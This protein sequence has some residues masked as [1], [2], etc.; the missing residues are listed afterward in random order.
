MNRTHSGTV[1]SKKMAFI[2]S[3]SPHKDN[4]VTCFD[5]WQ[6]MEGFLLSVLLVSEIPFW[7][8][9]TCTVHIYKML[10]R[11]KKKT[12]GPLTLEIF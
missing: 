11:H 8:A 9:S 3:L 10:E 12:T 6:M 4:I 5:G 7:Q 1:Y 2:P